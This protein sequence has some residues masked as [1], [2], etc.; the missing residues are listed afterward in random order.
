[1]SLSSPCWSLSIPA[2]LPSPY[3]ATDRQPWTVALEFLS[4]VLRLRD[5]VDGHTPL[6][7]AGL[8]N[9]FHRQYQ[10]P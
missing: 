7:T 4:A 8:T 3:K 9:G 1:M 10:S 2:I 6:P 5:A